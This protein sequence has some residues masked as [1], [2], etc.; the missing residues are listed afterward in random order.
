MF[1]PSDPLKIKG[2]DYKSIPDILIMS[3]K[4]FDSVPKTYQEAIMKAAEEAIPFQRKVWAD[5]V[6]EAVRE[7]KAKGME[8]NEVDDIREFQTIAKP[9]YKDYESTVGADL[10]EEIINYK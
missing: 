6:N 1:M 4:V 3:K 8:F 5:Y 9:I 10:I 7:L 2:E